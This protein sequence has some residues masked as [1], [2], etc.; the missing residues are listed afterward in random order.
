M[1]MKS[2]FAA[3]PQI[4]ATVL[5]QL[6][7]LLKRPNNRSNGKSCV[8]KMFEEFHHVNLLWSMNCFSKYDLDF[9]SV[10]NTFTGNWDPNMNQKIFSHSP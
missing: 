5:A 7:C 9:K 10:N 6:R 1:A 4:I 8:N 2:G 3:L